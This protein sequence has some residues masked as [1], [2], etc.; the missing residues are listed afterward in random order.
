MKKLFF[1]ILSALVFASLFEMSKPEGSIKGKIKDWYA[2]IILSSDN[3]ELKPTYYLVEEGD[4]IE[5]IA[6]RFR[7]RKYQL[8]KVNNMSPNETLYPGVKLVIPKIKYKSYEGRA[9]WYGPGFHGRKMANSEIYDQY[10]ILIAHR[11]LP[12]GTPV[13]VTNLENGRSITALVLDRGPYATDNNG[14]YSR[15]IDLSYGAAK[16]LGAIH[17]GVIPVKIE[18]LAI[19]GTNS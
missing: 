18:P 6:R 19:G 8:R 1:L 5:G 2:L 15:E 4:T 9:S 11:H 13:L 10:K 16:A 7:L 17:N 3:E 12:L 14:N